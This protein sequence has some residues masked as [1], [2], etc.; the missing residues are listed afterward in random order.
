M[1]NWDARFQTWNLVFICGMVNGLCCGFGCGIVIVYI[2]GMVNGFCFGFG[3]GIVISYSLYLGVE[4]LEFIYFWYL[5]YI[6][7]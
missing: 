2:C 1:E 3:W 7:F 5:I 6:F 4:K